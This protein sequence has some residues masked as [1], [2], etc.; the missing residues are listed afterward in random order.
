MNRFKVWSQPDVRKAYMNY[1]QALIDELRKKHE[2][3]SARKAQP[4]N[5]YSFASGFSGITF[6]TSFIRDGRV[7]VDL[8][9][10]FK[11]KER[12]KIFFDRLYQQK[13][14]FEDAFGEKL[15]WEREDDHRMC[16]LSIF[17]DGTI[18]SPSNTLDEIRKWSISN[19]L[20][21][22]KVLLPKIKALANDFAR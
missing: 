12:N 4:E 13:R 2:F 3:T 16:R 14:S 5:N 22:K 11:N 10:D 6:F 8:I 9:I 21:M 7:R 15:H 20:K 17:H 19:L 1:F 18:H